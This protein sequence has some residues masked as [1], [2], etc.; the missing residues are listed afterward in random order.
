MKLHTKVITLFIALLSLSCFEKKKEPIEKTLDNELKQKIGQ[1]IL[2]GFRGDSI[3]KVDSILKDQL[4]KGEIGGIILF[5]YDV[6]YKK[7][8]RNIKSPD[9]LKKLIADLQSLNEDQLFISIDQEGG[10][11]SRL[12]PKYGFPESVSAKYL[13]Q[14]DDVDTTL[15]Y[16][17]R[18]VKTLKS[19]GINLNFAPVV[20]MDIN[21]NN[22]VIGGYERSYSKKA[23]IVEKHAAIWIDAHAEAGIISTLKHFP[24][25][26]SADADSHK[27]ITDITN[28]WS[29]EELIPFR[30]LSAKKSMGIMTAHVMN[31]ELD[32]TYPA[33]L[34]K[35]VIKK[36][37]R[38]NFEFNGLV[39]SDDLQMKAVNAMFP[40]ETILKKAIE[41]DVDVLVVGNN[42]EYDPDI[43]SKMINAIYKMVQ[44]GEITEERIEESYQR[45]LKAKKSI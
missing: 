42:L 12:K 7:A 39:F 8:D 34:S 6:V 36:I 22:P 21:P 2:V 16:A 23:E 29:V 1:M 31:K 44:S 26:G 35:N 40:F 43:A 14:I 11:V 18:N 24:G 37:I 25:H 20:D 15:L 28:F 38:N 30:K 3:Q 4:K 45:V 27:G 9:Q 10:K 17:E 33:T 32:S 5:D 19:L 13:G 41:A